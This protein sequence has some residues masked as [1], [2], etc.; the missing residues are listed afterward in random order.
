[1]AGEQSQ[2]RPSDQTP[3]IGVLTKQRAAANYGGH[4]MSLFPQVNG[5]ST[6]HRAGQGNSHLTRQNVG[7]S[8]IE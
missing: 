2:T 8:S 3:S 5:F 7:R 1:M 4:G 6:T